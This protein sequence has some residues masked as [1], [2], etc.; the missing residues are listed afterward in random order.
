MSPDTKS[1]LKFALTL[2]FLFGLL[3]LVGILASGCASMRTSSST[4]RSC[5]EVDGCWVQER[6][7]FGSEFWCRMEDNTKRCI[8][9]R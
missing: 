3:A 8:Q 2:V 6:T 7:P 5:A 1:G 9:I 4:D